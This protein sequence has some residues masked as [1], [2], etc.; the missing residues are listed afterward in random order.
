MTMYRTLQRWAHEKPSFF[1]AIVLALSGPLLV[2]TVPPTRRYFGW[3]PPE[4]PPTSYPL[5]QRARR[6]VKGYDD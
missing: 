1:Y 6:E 3:V 5:P 2:V 4:A